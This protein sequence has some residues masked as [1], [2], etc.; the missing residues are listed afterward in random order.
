MLVGPHRAMGLL[1]VDITNGDGNSLYSE[2]IASISYL[3]LSNDEILNLVSTIAASLSTAL[4]K[5]SL[6]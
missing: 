3:S 1:G 5:W 6:T 2:S 4:H